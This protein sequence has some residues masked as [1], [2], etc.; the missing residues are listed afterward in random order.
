MA[1]A[2]AIANALAKLIGGPLRAAAD[3]APSAS[4]STC[5][6]W[7]RE[8]HRGTHA[9]R[10]ARGRGRGRAPGR[11]R[12]R[13]RR[14]RAPGQVPAAR[15]TS[16]PSTASPGSA[17]SPWT[18]A[19]L[20][21]G[22]L[23]NHAEIEASDDVR[24]AGRGL[25]DGS[26]LVGS[27]ATRNVGTIGGNVMNASPAMD[28]GAPLLVLGAEV[29]LRSQAGSRT[30]AV[31]RSVDGPGRDLAPATDELCVAVQVPALPARS[32]SAYV[33]LEYRRAMEIA[34]V[35]AAAAV[36]LNGDGDV[37]AC[38]VAL[39]AVAPTIV[40]RRAPRPRSP[41]SR[42][43]R[44]S[45]A[46]VAARR[47][48]RRRADQRRPRRRALPP[49]H[50]R[51]D[52]PPGRR[53][54]ASPARAASTSPSL[55]TAP[56]VSAR[57]SEA[58]PMSVSITLNV[59]GV[60]YPLTRRAA[61]QPRQRAAQRDRPH[62][63]QGGL[64]RLRV[65]RLHGAARRPAGELVLLPRRAGRRPRDHDRRG[66]GHG[67]RAAPAAAQHRRRG[68]RPVRVLHARACSSR[69]PPCWPRARSRARTRS[70]SRWAATSAAAP[71]TRRSSRAVQR[72][73]DELAGAR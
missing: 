10:G 1:T 36:T 6:R 5:R 31:V 4:G 8:L 37:E 3:D 48:R 63:H 25:A 27:P 47:E 54:R 53:G 41:A 13:P 62:R 16:S 55:P 68:R 2:A 32:G 11:R 22:A 45:L 52:G 42:S 23:V 21:L 50:R 14:R 59:N 49:P 56:P 28:T 65:R 67:R 46:A 39:T 18:A 20:V 43:T 30:V 71:A 64:R 9:R 72:T 12:H 69:R 33:R 60:A 7:A 38:R 57:P 40:A 70:A 17:T 15:A 61:S 58:E 19:T 26:A 73:A 51:R 44:T 66:P 24:P 34:V 35:G 29:E